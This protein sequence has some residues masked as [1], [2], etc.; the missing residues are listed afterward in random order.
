M[1][2]PAVGD[3]LRWK[4]DKEVFVILEATGVREYEASLN[5]PTIIKEYC[6]NVF[7]LTRQELDDIVYNRLNGPQ[8]EILA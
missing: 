6:Y 8:W 5:D 7:N 3:M 4:I 1:R 2:I